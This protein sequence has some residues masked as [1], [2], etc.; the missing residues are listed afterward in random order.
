MLGNNQTAATVARNLAR[1]GMDLVAATPD[2]QILPELR[3]LAATA[4]GAQSLE[5]LAETTVAGCSGSVG[6]F[7]VRLEKNGVKFSRRTDRVVI[8]EDFVRLPAF[9]DYG[10][11]ASPAA[12][13]LPQA[14]AAISGPAGE[15]PLPSEIQRVVFLLG[16]VNESHPMV[17]RDVMASALHFQQTGKQVY[18]LT[19]NLKVAAPGLE[20]LAREIRRAG[21]V[22]VKFTDTR[23]AISMTAGQGPVIQFE[24]EITGQR[25]RLSPDLIVV[26]EMVAPSRYLKELIRIFELEGDPNGFAQADNVHR[27]TVG[28]NRRGVLVA[29][30][31]RCVMSPEDCRMDADNAALNATAQQRVPGAGVPVHAEI[32]PGNCVRCLTCH[33]LCPHRAV[34]VDARVRIQAEACEACG[35]CAAE[36]PREAIRLNGFAGPTILEAVER[37]EG[38]GSDTPFTPS[39]AAICCSRSAA[40][41]GELAACLGRRLPEGLKIIEV[42]CAGSVSIRH[43]LG[44]FQQRVDGVLVLTCHDGNCHSQRGRRLAAERVDLLKSMFENVGFEKNRLWL[45]SL[46]SNMGTE[47]AGL[48]QAFEDRIRGLGP[49]QLKPAG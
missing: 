49:N 7:Q 41:A 38:H 30:P 18:L 42:P 1:V 13:S 22:I 36:C 24:D 33:R 8:C 23:P 39:I 26:D 28:T 34:T 14:V 10:L 43:L 9:A 46:A 5:L 44:L 12:V 25:F 21:V 32:D 17:A 2:S 3:H 27:F 45:R 35:I 6:N 15:Q 40:P 20:K 19:A 16:L 11:T 48:A 29:G 37:M 47:F 31:A 4:S